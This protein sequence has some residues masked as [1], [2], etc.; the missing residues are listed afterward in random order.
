MLETFYTLKNGVQI[1]K[2]GL[3]TWMIDNESVKET[4][5]KA[6]KVGYRHIDTAQAYENEEGIGL[7][8]KESNIPREQL[9]ITTKIKA[10]YKTYEEAY[11]S[12]DESL[13]KWI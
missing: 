6:I 7:G 4:V 5:K 13:K 2:L 1:P 10:E 8:I 12:I 9:F 11:N 3:G